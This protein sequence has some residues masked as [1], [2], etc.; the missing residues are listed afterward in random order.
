MYIPINIKKTGLFTKEGI[1]DTKLNEDVK[2]RIFRYTGKNQDSIFSTISDLEKQSNTK[3]ILFNQSVGLIGINP[4]EKQLLY[5]LKPKEYTFF[6][7]KKN[8]IKIITPTLFVLNNVLEKTNAT[9]NDSVDLNASTVSNFE[10]SP[11]NLKFGWVTFKDA[12]HF[13]IIGAPFQNFFGKE[14]NI[15]PANLN[16]YQEA[17]E[18]GDFI[19]LSKINLNEYL[20]RPCLGT[21]SIPQSQKNPDQLSN[22]LMSIFYGYPN[23]DLSTSLSLNLLDLDYTDDSHKNEFYLATFIKSYL[24]KNKIFCQTFNYNKNDSFRT[25][26]SKMDMSVGSQ[27]ELNDDLATILHYILEPI[28]DQKEKF[29]VAEKYW[30]LLQNINKTKP[31]KIKLS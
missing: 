3:N 4:D 20:Q 9:L 16:E 1:V 11:D 7:L 26:F 8:E 31:I 6:N 30:F 24:L 18:D 5:I 23:L 22:L 29:E 15:D 25:L 17:M 27:K 28:K 13:E 21:M 12:K 2:E 10:T 19:P 14:T